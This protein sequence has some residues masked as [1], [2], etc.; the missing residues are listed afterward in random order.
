MK[1]RTSDGQAEK[2]CSACNTWKP[3]ANFSPGGKS[4]EDS[5]GGLHCECK[6]CNAK[7]HRERYVVAKAIRKKIASDAS[8]A[9]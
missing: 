4:H 2:L 3:V 9:R 5:E 8:E 1:L 7:R 6:A